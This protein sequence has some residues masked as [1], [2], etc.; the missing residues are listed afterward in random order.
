MSYMAEL[1]TYSRFHTREEAEEFALRLE[2]SGIHSK[3]EW[4]KNILDKIYV[5]ETLDPLIAVKI[6][7]QDFQRANL[8]QESIVAN[9]LEE[10]NPDYY[11][12]SFT[13]TELIEVIRNETEWNSF[14]RALAKKILTDRKV[15]F[16]LHAITP[17]KLS[18]TPARIELVWLIVEYLLSIYMP[19]A[20][21]IIG[22]ATLYAYKTLPDGE[23]VKMYDKYTR[24]HAKAIF[25]IGC[26]RCLLIFVSPWFILPF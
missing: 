24:D 7:P 16:D 13:D 21:I 9:D 26:V 15:S 12:F 19:V 3:V 20:G 22:L 1:S 4:E 5:G 14:D 23:K 2:E 17:R 18:Y 25:A 8:V 10:I 6:A 11:L